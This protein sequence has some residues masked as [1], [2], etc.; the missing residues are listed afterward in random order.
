MAL[1]VSPFF[2]LKIVV[3][4]SIILQNL[5]PEA[6]GWI[7][8]GLQLPSHDCVK[9]ERVIE[10]TCSY[11]FLSSAGASLATMWNIA[12]WG[13]ACGP[14]DERTSPASNKSSAYTFLLL[15]REELSTLQF[16]RFSQMPP[17]I[18]S[19]PS[20]CIIS[21]LLKK[22]SSNRVFRT[23]AVGILDCKKSYGNIS[24]IM[25]FIHA[26]TNKTYCF[27]KKHSIVRTQFVHCFHEC[28][29]SALVR[30]T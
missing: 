28:Y 30:K 7:C 2:M 5:L 23:S 3:K 6:L 9:E 15:Y 4:Q 13:R 21:L 22:D 27:N 8:V 1:D 24:S 25:Y 10:Q 20:T 11:T 19:F 18:I 26:F 16:L 12:L 29:I 17:L 14:S